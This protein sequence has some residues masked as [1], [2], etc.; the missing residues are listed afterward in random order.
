MIKCEKNSLRSIF[1]LVY[2]VILVTSCNVEQSDS[3]EP[4]TRKELEK[5]ADNLTKTLKPWSVP[6]RVF[7][8][9]DYGT[10]SDGVTLNT[11]AIQN[12]IDDCSTKGGGVVRFSRGN[13]LTGT[14]TFKSNVMIEVVEGARIMGS[15]SL[16]DYP[17]ISPK[18][19]TG[20]DTREKLT[21][22]IFYAEGVENIGI[23]G[24]G[25]IDGQG[26][27]GIIKAVDRLVN[28]PLVIRMYD[29]KNIVIENIDLKNSTAWMQ[30]YL[31]CED[32]II[33]GIKVSNYGMRNNDGM[34][35]DGCNR[36]IVRNCEVSSYDDAICLKGNSRKP[37]QNI[38]IENCKAYTN[39][40]AFKIGT[41][42]QGDFKRIVV[43]NCTLG[44]NAQNDKPYSSSGITVAS[45]DGG[46][47]EGLWAYNNTINNARCPVYI[48]RNNRGRVMEGLPKPKIGKVSQIIIE[49]TNGNG[50]INGGAV[51]GIPGFPVENI[52]ISNFNI[53]IQGSSI[54]AKEIRTFTQGEEKLESNST[55]PDAVFLTAD[56]FYTGIDEVPA[57]PAK[58]FTLRDVKSISFKDFSVTPQ[59][60][61]KR[62][63]FYLDKN[64]EASG[65]YF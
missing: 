33:Q 13:Y 57:L 9:E 52:L 1:T 2:L 64:V 18:E 41:D 44:G 28:R 3:W 15:T 54:G 12:A 42:T 31:D 45:V 17:H 50:N 11:T 55:Y 62:Q 36:V 29:S 56:R 34:D 19:V 37:T 53:G 25:I 21:M 20:M 7:L 14:I 24:K 59:K 61:D 26:N 48:V 16:L 49:N 27:S 5:M 38:L 10:K 40:N 46:N 23:R 35:I 32:L 6:K 8:V 22:S 47:V 58:G 51:S 63:L 30:L 65:I 60:E 43:R 39:W 4:D